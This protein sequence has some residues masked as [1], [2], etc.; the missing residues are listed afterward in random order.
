MQTMT[1]EEREAL[2]QQHKVWGG[3]CGEVRGV[4]GCSGAR[5]VTQAM[6]AAAQRWA[7]VR[8]CVRL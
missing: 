8:E 7:R 2:K 1:A 4:W 3:R 6:T 5:E